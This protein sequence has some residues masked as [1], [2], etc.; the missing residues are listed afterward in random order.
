MGKLAFD[1]VDA[2]I[3]VVDETT[4]TPDVTIQLVDGAGN[5]LN[6]SRAIFAYLAKDA[7]GAEICA[8]G[9]DTSEFVI[10]TDGLF[11]ETLADI[12]GFLVSE[13]DGDIDVTITIVTTKQAYLVLVM[14]DGRLVI[15]DKMSYTAG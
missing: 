8:D 11:V 6:E 5:D 2:V 9:T 10:K 1:P 4:A 14:P 15:S 7:A 13:S 3:T 12:A